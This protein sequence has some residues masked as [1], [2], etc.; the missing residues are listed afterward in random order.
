MLNIDLEGKI[1]LVVGGSRGIGAAITETLSRAGARVT[2]THT[3]D[4]ERRSAVES[5]VTRVQ[6]EGSHITAVVAEARDSTLM[7]SLVDALVREHG[8]L[9]ILVQNAGVVVER[10]VETISVEE[11]HRCLDLNL[12]AAFCSVRAVLSP[13]VKAGYGRI[14][15]IG[16][17]AVYDGG[18][19]A[20]DYAAAKAG[21]EGMMKY[22]AKTYARRGIL[23]NVI[24]PGPVDTELLRQR[25]PVGAP[26]REKLIAQ[27]PTGRLGKP[28]DIAGMVAFL[29]SS[30]GDF[31]CG[32][33]LLVDGGR[34][35]YRLM[36]Q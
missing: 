13:M 23:P 15:L 17:S 26:A 31:I 35:F 12:T 14:I 4:P 10:C 2:F 22:L 8:S 18:G 16:S 36:P 6:A 33:S 20:I 1:A 25:Y 5:L 30:W 3:G 32:Q 34:T 27:M 24:H 9:D 21:L 7:T 28:E 29:A 19:G 11:W